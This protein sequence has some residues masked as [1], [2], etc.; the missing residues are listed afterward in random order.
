MAVKQQNST[1][2]S[3]TLLRPF[4]NDV[5]KNKQFSKLNQF[6]DVKVPIKAAQNQPTKIINGRILLK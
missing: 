6:M 1:N 4:P 3:V 5:Y 2:I